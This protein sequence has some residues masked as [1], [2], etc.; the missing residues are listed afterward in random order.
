MLNEEEETNSKSAQF[1][2]S[3]QLKKHHFT[4][5]GLRINDKEKP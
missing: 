2:S 5:N 1:E 3:I 4:S